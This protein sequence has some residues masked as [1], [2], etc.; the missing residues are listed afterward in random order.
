MI[1][2]DIVVCV[3]VILLLCCSVFGI[4]IAM[5]FAEEGNTG[6][7]ARNT[8]LDYSAIGEGY[9]ENKSDPVPSCPQCG[10]ELYNGHCTW[11]EQRGI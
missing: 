2:I 10:I 1:H 3:A 6:P 11:C 8:L 9:G 7:S 4:M 5:H